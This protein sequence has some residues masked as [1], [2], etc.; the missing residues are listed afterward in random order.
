MKIGNFDGTTQEFNDLIENHG[1]NPEAFLDIKDPPLDK[2]WLYIPSGLLL[3]LIIIMLLIDNLNG[4][5]FALLFIT[6]LAIGSWLI[7]CVQ[8]RFK[9]SIATFVSAMC[10]LLILLVSSGVVDPKDT[11]QYLKNMTSE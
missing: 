7:V 9:N 11:P 10:L 5:Y 8:L 3:T 6:G 1:F 2:K 4:K